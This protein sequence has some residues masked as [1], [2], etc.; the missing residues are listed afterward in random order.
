MLPDSSPP[1]PQA[2]G[3]WWPAPRSPP[4]RMGVKARSPLWEEGKRG[5]PDGHEELAACCTLRCHRA[6]QG[7][8]QVRVRRGKLAEREFGRGCAHRG[9]PH[10][11]HV[12]GHLFQ[13]CRKMRLPG[14]RRNGWSPEEDFG[15]HPGDSAWPPYAGH[16]ERKAGSWSVACEDG[17]TPVPC[18]TFQPV[19]WRTAQKH[20]RQRMVMGGQRP[21]APPVTPAPVSV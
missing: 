8:C 6:P 14:L 19:G 17:A 9:G 10:T 12:P 1:R 13:S 20:Q 15:Q 11:R 21:R 2:V 5:M 4:A 16:G 18:S 3:E 7:T